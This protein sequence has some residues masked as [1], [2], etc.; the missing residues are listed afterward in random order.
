[1]LKLLS[2]AISADP[3]ACAQ[4]NLFQQFQTRT[5]DLIARLTNDAN[6]Y[7]SLVIPRIARLHWRRFSRR[8][9]TENIR[10]HYSAWVI[11]CIWRA[12]A[13]RGAAEP[14]SD[15][16]QYFPF[17]FSDLQTAELRGIEALADGLLEQLL[18]AV[19]DFDG[20]SEGEDSEAGDDD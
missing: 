5:D 10:R 17:N 6:Y 16:S 2:S 11:Q 1:M 15:L 9:Y 8:L 4:T 18:E 3:S 19:I 13:G 20:E 7:E 12:R 14:P